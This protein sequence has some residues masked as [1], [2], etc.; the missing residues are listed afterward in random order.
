MRP[1]L[2]YIEATKGAINAA[3]IQEINNE[4]KPVY[5]I[6]MMLQGV[7]TWYQVKEKITLSLTIVARQ[8]QPYF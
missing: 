7:E 6:S 8:L 2:I 4:Q 1:F 5:I 3:L